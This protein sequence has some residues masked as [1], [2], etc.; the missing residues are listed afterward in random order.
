MIIFPEGTRSTTGSL[1]PFKIGAFKLAA[2]TGTKVQPVI[3]QNY[4]FIDHEKKIF[5]HGELKIRIL[6]ALMLQSNETVDEFSQ[7]SYQLMNSEFQKL[8]N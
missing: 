3:I 6:P 1:L 5:G 8:N 4:N 2:L 7:R